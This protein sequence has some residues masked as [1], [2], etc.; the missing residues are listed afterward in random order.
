MTIFSDFFSCFV[1]LS[2]A[3]WT[4]SKGSGEIACISLT[5]FYFFL[6]LFKSDISFSYMCARGCLFV[7]FFVRST[8]KNSYQCLG[9]EA[10]TSLGE[11]APVPEG[12][13][14][15]QVWMGRATPH[16]RFLNRHFQCE[17]GA[18]EGIPVCP[19]YLKQI[20]QEYPPQALPCGYLLI[21]PLIFPFCTPL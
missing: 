10:A 4:E 1:A 15:C 18:G 2:N 17:R 19:S 14:S 21:V 9:E 5:S 6:F 13:R 8:F 12:S 11:A 16:Q 7:F 20:Q 3:F